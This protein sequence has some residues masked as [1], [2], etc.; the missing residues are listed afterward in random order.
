MGQHQGMGP[1]PEIAVTRLLNTY[2]DDFELFYNRHSNWQIEI[3]YLDFS[4][5][6]VGSTPLEVMCEALRY[7]EDS[8]D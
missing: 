7:L 1:T 5:V 4:T 8:N 3:T 2:V 6:I